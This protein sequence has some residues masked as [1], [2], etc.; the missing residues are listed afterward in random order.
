MKS[1]E[2]KVIILRARPETK[3][4]QIEGD[5]SCNVTA[6]NGSHTFAVTFSNQIN[7]IPND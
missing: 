7:I 2:E 6:K 3:Y 1:E 4:H 5:I